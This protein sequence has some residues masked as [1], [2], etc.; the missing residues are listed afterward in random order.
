MSNKGTCFFKKQKY[1]NFILL[2]YNKN[3]ILHKKYWTY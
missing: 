1:L 3:E 2:V